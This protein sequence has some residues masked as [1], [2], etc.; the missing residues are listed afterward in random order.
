M[1]HAP[2]KTF[3]AQLTQGHWNRE[4][5]IVYVVAPCYDDAVDALLNDPGIGERWNFTCTL[6]WIEEKPEKTLVCLRI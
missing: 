6:D 3:R 2:L 1:L 4:K 5:Q